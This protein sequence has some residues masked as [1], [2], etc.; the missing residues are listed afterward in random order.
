MKIIGIAGK[1]VEHWDV[2]QV[3]PPTADNPNSMF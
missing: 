2:L 1:L 3:A